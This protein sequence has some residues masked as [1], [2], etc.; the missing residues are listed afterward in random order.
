[1][2]PKSDQRSGLSSDQKKPFVVAAFFFLIL[3][4]F[5]VLEGKGGR[6]GLLFFSHFLV[7]LFCEMMGMKFLFFYAF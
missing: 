7:L 5:G 6:A 1:M 4:F 2:G 3:F